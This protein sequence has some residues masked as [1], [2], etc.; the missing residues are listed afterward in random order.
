MY[1]Y[2]FSSLHND[3]IVANRIRLLYFSQLLIITLT[4]LLLQLLLY[5]LFVVVRCCFLLLLRANSVI[6]LCAVKFASKKYR[7]Y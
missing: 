7:F 1:V 5:K 3:V 4:E 2:M 6:C